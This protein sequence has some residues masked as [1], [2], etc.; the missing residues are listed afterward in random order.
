[1]FCDVCE[2]L[3]TGDLVGNLI[4]SAAEVPGLVFSL[5]M[6]HFC[7]RKL[8]FAIPMGAIP[9]VLIPLMAGELLGCAAGYF[10][11]YTRTVPCTVLGWCKVW[12]TRCASYF[13]SIKCS[14]SSVQHFTG[15]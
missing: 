13:S 7:S 8:A 10:C 15:A 2:L 9:V 4:T 12:C 3:Q 11:A 1:M 14:R 6:I 5:F